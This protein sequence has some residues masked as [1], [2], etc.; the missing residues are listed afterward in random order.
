MSN[1]KPRGAAGGTGRERENEERGE[2]ESFCI[3]WIAYWF[4]EGH[5]EGGAL[6]IPVFVTTEKR[7]ERERSMCE[8]VMC[9]GLFEPV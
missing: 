4:K 2:A 6:E 3:V 5:A 7:R 1:K 8:S 9:A